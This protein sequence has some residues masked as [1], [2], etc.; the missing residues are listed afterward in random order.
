MQKDSI[1]LS[2]RKERGVKGRVMLRILRDMFGGM[3]KGMELRFQRRFPFE[4]EMIEETFLW[5]SLI[6]SGPIRRLRRVWFKIHRSFEREVFT[7][8][9]IV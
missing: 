4:M 5:Y 7:P 1:G 6:G 8:F 9:L 3:G 2:Q